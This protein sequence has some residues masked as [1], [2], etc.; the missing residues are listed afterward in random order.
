MVNSPSASAVKSKAFTLFLLLPVHCHLLGTEKLAKVTISK[1]NV[2]DMYSEDL[3]VN[4]N[5]LH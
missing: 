5:R 4:T 3:W 1:A 2:P